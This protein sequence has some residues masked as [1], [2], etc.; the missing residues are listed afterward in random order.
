M[1][2]PGV[3]GQTA[4]LADPQVKCSALLSTAPF[5]KRAFASAIALAANVIFWINEA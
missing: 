5:N 1:P 3:E 4:R 2:K